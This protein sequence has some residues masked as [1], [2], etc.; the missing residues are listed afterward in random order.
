ML[1]LLIPFAIGIWGGDCLFFQGISLSF[2]FVSTSLLVSPLLLLIGHFFVKRYAFRWLFGL[3]AFLS[4]MVWGGCLSYLYL[5]QSNLEY[6]DREVVYRAVI[7]STPE[8]KERSILCRADLL[9]RYDSTAVV[10]L[11]RKK[12]L[13]YFSLDSLGRAIC[14]GDEMLLSAHVSLPRNNGNPDEFDYSRYIRR[15]GIS[16]TAFVNT[17]KWKVIGNRPDRSFRKMA[18]DYRNNILDIYRSLGFSGDEFA[19]LSALTVGYKEE[20]SEEI[21]ESFSVSGASHVLALSGLHIGFLYALLLLLL[22]WLPDRAYRSVK[23]FKVSFVLIVLWGFAFVTGLSPSVVRSVTMFSLLAISHLLIH[24]HIESLNTLAVAGIG[25]L[26]YNPAWLFDVGFQLSFSAVISIPIIHPWLYGKLTVRSALLEKIWGLTS[27]SIAAQIG[28]APLVLLY[29]SRFSV[30]SLLTNLLVIPLVVVLVYTAIFLLLFHFVPFV[31]Q[32]AVLLLKGLLVLLNKVVQLI[33][34]LPLASVDDIWIYRLEVI[35]FYIFLLFLLGYV[36]KRRATHLM[37]CLSVLLV[38]SLYRVWIINREQPELSVVFYNVRHCPAVHCISSDGRS[39]IA[40]ADSVPESKRLVRVAS[41]NWRRY[42]LS[43]PVSVTDDYEG[44][45]FLRRNN[46]LLF[47]GKRICIL[48][49]NRWNMLKT[50][51]LFRVDCVYLC[52]G[53]D[54]QIKELI[55]V[56]D[57]NHVVFD[58]SFPVYR[59][60]RLQKECEDLDIPYISLAENASYYKI[61]I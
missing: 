60:L 33:E 22:K 37:A 50:E 39:W 25:M 13:L 49:D 9:E 56:F 47:A 42:R 17:G 26:M 27:V 8:E 20:L 58:S 18:L 30:Y 57:M 19:V 44:G 4:F 1:R 36:Y 7:T 48:N 24:R 51:L 14:H 11:D 32:V 41:N 53:Y 12:V 54:G 38:M 28:T 10:P 59:R 61:L 16:G 21:R 31:N 5:E 23:W 29:F 46:I 55:E 2:S 3:L 6:P 15:K 35:L 45:D 34:Q 40:Y 43:D 52:K